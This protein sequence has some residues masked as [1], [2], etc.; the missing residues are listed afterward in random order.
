MSENIQSISQ[1][2]YTIGQTSATNFVAGP[3][4]KIDEPSAGTVRIGI[5]GNEWINV[6]DEVN[7]NTNLINAGGF[8]IFYNKALK[9]V[10]LTCD[11]N[12]KAGSVGTVFMTWT[13]R[14]TPADSSQFGLG[15]SLY[16]ASTNLNQGAGQASRWINGCWT[17][18]VKGE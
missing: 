15:T 13:D 4:I 5:D 10:T 2:T 18:G 6:I 14:L 16:V 8:R 1:G 3:G 12:V 17:W 11:V 9:L 7:Y